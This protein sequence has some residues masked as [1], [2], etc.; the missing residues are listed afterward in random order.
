[1]LVLCLYRAT[2]TNYIE[3]HTNKLAAVGKFLSV[4][5]LPHFN[6]EFFYCSQMPCYIQKICKSDLLFSKSE[7]VTSQV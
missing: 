6:F 4:L 1:M 7:I 2:N 5:I 3:F